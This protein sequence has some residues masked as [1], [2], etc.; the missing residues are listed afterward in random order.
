MCE[1]WRVFD[2]F[3]ADMGP[4]PG[5]GFT[6]DRVDVNGDY[7]PDNCRWAT[8]IEQ[9]RNQ[10]PRVGFKGSRYLLSGVAECLGVDVGE[11][12]RRVWL[13]QLRIKACAGG[14]VV[15]LVG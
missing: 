3:A 4:H 10:R 14:A 15:S 2:A 13:N 12:G 8:R 9:R 1:R 5:K 11:L 6:L 7:S